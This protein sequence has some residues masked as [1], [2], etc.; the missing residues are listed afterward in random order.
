MLA[1][2]LAVTASIALA[3]SMEK[4]SVSMSTSTGLAPIAST[5]WRVATQ[6]KAG[7]SGSALIGTGW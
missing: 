5:G 4:V 6:V 1:R 2:V 7:K 3:G